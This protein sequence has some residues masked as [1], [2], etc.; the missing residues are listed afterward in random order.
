MVGRMDGAVGRAPWLPRL[1][2]CLNLHDEEAKLAGNRRV[3]M[4]GA[5]VGLAI[6]R[7][8]SHDLVMPDLLALG[9]IALNLDRLTLQI[10]AG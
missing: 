10:E 7:D 2:F 8:R 1:A 9:H 3:C 4:D 6:C 5:L